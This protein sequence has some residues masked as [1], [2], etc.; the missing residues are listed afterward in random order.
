ML[1]PHT[2]APVDV[3]ES[4]RSIR[5][6]T[7]TTE[8]IGLPRD[9]LLQI[10]ANNP[11]Q[12]CQSFGI[13]QGLPV[14]E[15]LYNGENRLI[16]IA[17]AGLIPMPANVSNYRERAAQVRL[18]SHNGMKSDTTRE[19]V[20]DEFAGTG[21]GGRIADV[22]SEA[23]IPTNTFSINGQQVLLSGEGGQ[24]PSQFILDD[25]GL[26]DFNNDPSFENMEEVIKAMNNATL[27]ES[28]FFAE[29]WSSK[30]SEIFVKQSLLKAELDATTVNTVF[31]EPESGLADQFKIVTRVM[32]TAQAR[33]VERDIFYVT[34]GGFDTHSNVDEKLIANFA[35]MNAAFQGFIN[36][37]KALNLWSSTVLVQFSEFGR[38]LDPN[39]NFGSD[40]AWGG[41]HFMFGGAVAGGK[42]LG[43]YPREFEQ[44]DEDGI[45]LKRGR[46]IPTSPWDS[47]WKGVA[48]W[49]GVPAEG[50]GMDKVLPMHKNFP[51]D[52]LYNKNQL[53]DV[54][55][56]DGDGSTS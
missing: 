3:Y 41:N 30:L 1:A 56:S 52:K 10:D 21:V 47:M 32:Q 17:N 31:P 45:A 46:M 25:D 18:Y 11:S 24:G 5:G 27:A 55:G 13:H 48:E 50:A 37:L 6:K 26:A 44:G 35:G 4:Y 54:L 51:S 43:Q 29:T 23:G 20:F 28:G 8:G 22:L 42:V 53:F 16:F 34:S 7:N 36:E 9:R 19:D 2:C 14:L 38:T 33:G 15:N 49:F 39:T 40:H 12:P